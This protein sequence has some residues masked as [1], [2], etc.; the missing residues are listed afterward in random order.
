MA[1][2]G[3]QGR[4]LDS[5]PQALV[6]LLVKPEAGACLGVSPGWC[7][8]RG[9][10][11]ESEPQAKDTGEREEG[12]EHTHMHAHTHT[13]TDC[14]LEGA[15]LAVKMLN[16]QGDGNIPLVSFMPFTGTLRDETFPET[17][18]R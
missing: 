15:V 13:H 1:T 14:F 10:G 4:T 9:S 11:H 7:L 6:S 3:A 17:I 12:E 8:H 18:K 5:E 2:W 16:G